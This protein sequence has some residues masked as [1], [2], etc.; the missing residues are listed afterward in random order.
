MVLFFH[1]DDRRLP[2]AAVT[3]VVK[4]FMPD[5]FDLKAMVLVVNYKNLEFELTF[6]DERSGYIHRHSPIRPGYS[7]CDIVPWSTNEEILIA[8]IREFKVYE[9]EKIFLRLVEEWGKE[10]T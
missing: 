3:D 2:I 9:I 8:S 4:F 10:P 6:S 5:E 7:R 1:K